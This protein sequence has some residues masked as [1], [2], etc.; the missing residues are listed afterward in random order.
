MVDI[1]TDSDTSPD[2]TYIALPLWYK[3]LV[4]TG[5]AGI[6]GFF[7][8][9]HGITG[10]ILGAVGGVGAGIYWLD[11]VGGVPAQ[12][13][14]AERPDGIRW[15]AVAGVIDTLW[16]HIAY[17]FWLY[18]ADVYGERISDSRA[19]LLGF[20][21]LLLIGIILGIVSGA[22][23]GAI[24]MMVLEMHLARKRRGRADG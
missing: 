15:G 24:C 8:I 4:C 5:A 13:T 18:I 16:L 7:G 9:I 12:S 17:G 11:R 1:A 3:I 21:G 22:V 23:Y 14:Y 10:I 20:P 2:V 6:G 19:Y